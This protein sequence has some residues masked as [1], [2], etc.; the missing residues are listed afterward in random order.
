MKVGVLIVLQKRGFKAGF[1]G[2]DALIWG[3]FLHFKGNAATHE[4]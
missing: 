3:N 4:E 2:I 1:L